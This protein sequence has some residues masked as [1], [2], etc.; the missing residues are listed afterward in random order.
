[1]QNQ[2]TVVFSAWRAGNDLITNIEASKRVRIF[3][4]ECKLPHWDAVGAFKEANHTHHTQ[5]VS[6]V[7]HCADEDDVLALITYACTV[8]AQ[9][10]V[11]V[12]KSSDNSASLE[13]PTES[14]DLGTLTQVNQALARKNEVYTYFLGDYYI[15]E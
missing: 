1:M 2:Y 13:S 3:L 11:L 5:E 9:D 14:I 4:D 8:F 15:C 7:V 6:H 12:V 10:C